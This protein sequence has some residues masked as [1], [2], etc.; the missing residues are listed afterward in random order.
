MCDVECFECNAHVSKNAADRDNFLVR[1]FCV[2]KFE[3]GAFYALRVAVSLTILGIGKLEAIF[4]VCYNF[5]SPN[6]AINRDRWAS[7]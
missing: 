5:S 7:V 3:I 6:G 2:I 4:F 1:C